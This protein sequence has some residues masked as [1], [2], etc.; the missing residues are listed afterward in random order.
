MARKST[1]SVIAERVRTLKVMVLSGS[2]NSVC[3]DHATAEWGLSSRQAYRLVKRAWSSIHADVDEVGIDRREMLAWCIHQLQ[4]AAAQGLAKNNTGAT[5][6]AVRELNL[7]LGL[8]AHV[9]S[10]H[11]R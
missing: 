8:G 1:D 3:V 2:S 4:A 5:V 6:S 11:R 9:S 7:L 10:T